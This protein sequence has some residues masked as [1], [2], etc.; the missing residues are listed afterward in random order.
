MEASVTATGMIKP[1][2]KNDRKFSLSSLKKSVEV[3]CMIPS[4]TNGSRKSMLLLNRLSKPFSE[5]WIYKGFVKMNN[6]RKEA[7]LAK[8][9]VKV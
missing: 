4:E 8:K 3:L 1:V 2:V 9:L 6:N 7:P 5:G